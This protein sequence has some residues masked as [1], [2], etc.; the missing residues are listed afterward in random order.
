MKG[1]SQ[2]GSASWWTRRCERGSR[3]EGGPLCWRVMMSPGLWLTSKRCTTSCLA[4]ERREAMGRNRTPPGRNSSNTRML[5]SEVG[6]RA[7][8]R[9]GIGCR[10]ESESR[11]RYGAAPGAQGEGADD[12][13]TTDV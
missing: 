3:A 1:R 2:L 8:R 11:S 10:Q 7:L 13:G 5:K 4:S 12:E 9:G 6:L